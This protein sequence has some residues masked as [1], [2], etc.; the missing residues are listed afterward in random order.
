MAGEPTVVGT[1]AGVVC[2]EAAVVRKL[3]VVDENSLLTEVETSAAVF[4]VVNKI[5]ASV[6]I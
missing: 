5:A 1:E 3:C 6:D 4:F 2:A